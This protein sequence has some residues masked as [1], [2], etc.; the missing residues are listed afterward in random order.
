MIVTILGFL[1]VPTRQNAR[2]YLAAMFIKPIYTHNVRW[3]EII[4]LAVL[5]STRATDMDALVDAIRYDGLD[6]EIAVV[7]CN[8]K[9]PALEKAKGFGIP[10]VYLD[11]AG[12]SRE[13]YDRELI[14]A[15]QK[16]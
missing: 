11:S 12:K 6:A 5:S 10:G 1:P 7:I 13:E 15:L 4:R 3:F 8:K 2:K 16:H 9:C 14:K